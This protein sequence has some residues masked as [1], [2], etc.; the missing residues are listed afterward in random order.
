MMIISDH[1][2]CDY[3]FYN[4]YLLIFYGVFCI[5]SLMIILND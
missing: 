5:V 2:L 4:E 1:V 3:D